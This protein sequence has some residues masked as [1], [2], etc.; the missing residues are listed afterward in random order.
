[1][2]SAMRRRRQP[3]SSASP[4]YNPTDTSALAVLDS[5]LV[6]G[7]DIKGRGGSSFSFLGEGDITSL[8]LQTDSSELP[9]Q[10]GK[11]P[12]TS[13]SFPN[14]SASPKVRYKKKSSETLIGVST[15]FDA[16]AY[17]L[18][19]DKYEGDESPRDYSAAGGGRWV[20]S[21]RPDSRNELRQGSP[22]QQR[23]TPS[24]NT[25]RSRNGLPPSSPPVQRNA[26]RPPSSRGLVSGIAS[27]TPS[28]PFK[29]L[30]PLSGN[31]EEDSSTKGAS[32]ELCEANNSNS[33]DLSTQ[34]TGLWD[35][36]D[37]SSG[38]EGLVS[39]QS[40]SNAKGK[41]AS[42]VHR[43]SVIRGTSSGRK[44]EKDEE[45]ED[46]AIDHLSRRKMCAENVVLQKTAASNVMKLFSQNS[47]KPK[48]SQ[49]PLVIPEESG[50]DASRTKT[51][52]LSNHVCSE[53]FPLT[54]FFRLV[55]CLDSI[56]KEV[57]QQSINGSKKWTPKTMMIQILTQSLECRLPLQDSHHQTFLT[58]DRKRFCL[59]IAF[60]T[61]YDYDHASLTLFVV[62]PQR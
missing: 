58:L 12:R 45:D 44:I 57:W 62:Y 60:S 55:V 26:S 20:Q 40:R 51:N 42:L 53:V 24:P 31:G 52:L 59:E 46:F 39:S 11:S 56:S 19:M 3:K 50:V 43:N 49:G 14:L 38:D 41:Y 61:W 28:A 16:E 32:R 25:F 18:G 34:K 35:V 13:T 5:A 1:M 47:A 23:R 7:G 33:A 17:P 2:A 8:V 9:T 54:I 36:S 29:I 10:Y 15:S 21:P 48:L 6:D 27:I 37:D 30:I 4:D 22:R